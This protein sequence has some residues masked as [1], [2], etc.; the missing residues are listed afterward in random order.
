MAKSRTPA[1]PDRETEEKILDAAQLVFIRR[2]TAGARMAEIAKEAGVNQALLHY[3]FRSKER[4]ANAVFQQIALRIFPAL[5]ETLASDG[6]LDDKIDRL[7]ALYLDNLSRSPFL[8]AYII[9]E[10]HH[11]PERV[12]QLLSKA[13][14]AKP[15]GVLSPLLRKLAAQIDEAVAAG[16]MRPIPPE[17][18]AVNLISLCIFPFAARP[19][20]RIVF[21][22][23]DHA[24][25]RFIEQRKTELPAFF[26]NALRP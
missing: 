17:E 20:L 8:P 22:M 19:M 21:G 10:L 3:Y 6:S 14:G 25:A 16:T 26:R 7:I 1:P 15:K 18:F 4:L 23:D 5:A 2:G 12:E 9:A 13:M 24:F 11:H